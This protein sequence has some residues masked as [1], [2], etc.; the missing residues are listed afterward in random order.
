MKAIIITEGGRHIGLG[1]ITR[2]VSLYQAFEKNKISPELIV[3]GDE[4]V[5]ELLADKQYE[6]FN[7]LDERDKLFGHIGG[8]DIAVIDSYLADIDFYLRVSGTIKIPVYIDD[9]MRLDYPQG[10]VVN[11]GI[12]AEEL[13]YPEASGVKYLLG[14][15]YIPLRKE[16]WDLQEKEIKDA[17]KSVM[18]TFGGDDARN[19]TPVVLSLLIERFPELIK[20]VIIG[21]GFKNMKEVTAMKDAKTELV[22][23]PDAGGMRRVML[24]SDI[25]ISAGGQT[26]YELARAGVPTIAVAVAGNQTNNV[27][28]WERAGFIE[29]AGWWEDKGVLEN[30]EDALHLLREKNIRRQMAK[31]GRTLV[32]GL[33]AERVCSEVSGYAHR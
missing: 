24:E 18:I 16:F 22:L 14:A 21:K 15:K 33:G 3:N 32:D 6:I 8:A 29:Y 20:R 10:V 19:M 13:N 4:T 7:W 12:C 5:K 9:A 17:I 31:I 25:A 1:H 23:Y 26:L 28:G 30:V 27:K 2:C 11:G